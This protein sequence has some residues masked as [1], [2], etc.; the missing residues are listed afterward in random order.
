MDMDGFFRS[1]YRYYLILIPAADIFVDGAPQHDD[2]TL[3]VMKL[4]AV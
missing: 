3:V 4:A 2:M 1:Q